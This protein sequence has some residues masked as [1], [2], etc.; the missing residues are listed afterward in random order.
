M[1]LKD[2]LWVVIAGL[3]I[4]IW[5]LFDD[6]K[7]RAIKADRIIKRLR[8]E[9]HEIKNAYLGLFDKHLKIIK[10]VDVGII[11]EVQKLKNNTDILDF[12]VHLELEQVV[13]NLTKGKSSEA[14][15]QLAKIIEKKL[16]EKVKK[17][18]SFKGKPML[19]SLLQFAKKCDWITS[20]QFENGLALK[21]IRNKES[22]E[23]NV[24]E[25]TRVIAL[26]IFSGIDLIYAL[27]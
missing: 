24:E 22:H 13:E 11:E 23:L 17:E 16:K 7:K 6:K 1:K 18:E 15:R 10:N 8:K 27:K 3:G 20:R 19:H 4:F 5:W 12:E 9:N 26:S 14:V 2:I 21:E 25:E